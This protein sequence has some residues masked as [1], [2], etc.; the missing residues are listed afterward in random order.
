[1]I[2]KFATWDKSDFFCMAN[3]IG[4]EKGKLE[5]HLEFM[6]KKMNILTYHLQFIEFVLIYSYE[7]T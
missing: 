5:N 7:K 2:D 4:K 1:M 6:W 3:S